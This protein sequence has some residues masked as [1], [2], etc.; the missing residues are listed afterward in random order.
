MRGKAS[1]SFGS[2]ESSAF[3]IIRGTQVRILVGP[4]KSN[5]RM[6]RTAAL[7]FLLLAAGCGSGDA[8][9]GGGGPTEPSQPPE[10]TTVVVTTTETVTTEPAPPKELPTPV[11]ETRQAIIAA[12]ESHDYEALAALIP[13][14]GFTYSYGGPAEGGAV[15]YWQD[16]EE[17]G[18]TPLAT[19]GG[20]LALRHT[21]A[22]DIYVWPWAYDKDPA[23]LTDD[24]KETLAAAG[25]ASVEQLDQM[26]E[27]G[28]YLGWRLGIRRDGT[29]MFFVAGD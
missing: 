16:L 27:F 5:E 8:Q 6:K 15:G 26:A 25:A 19:M 2:S 18:E 3:L 12:A 10:T 21:R 23:D 13:A 9:Q 22:G 7:L 24:Q 28:H 11:E 1:A 4:S 14:S 29:W 17:G 20:L